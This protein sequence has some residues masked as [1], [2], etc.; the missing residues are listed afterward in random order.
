MT[1]QEVETLLEEVRPVTRS[2]ARKFYNDPD[3]SAELVQQHALLIWEG[4]RKLRR[5]KNP[6]AYV[7]ARM[8]YLCR[9]AK[10]QDARRWAAGYQEGG[11]EGLVE[12]TTHGPD[13][14]GVF[15]ENEHF[16]NLEA[17]S[18]ANPLSRGDELS[19]LRDTDVRLAV[20]NLDPQV[21]AVVLAVQVEGKSINEVSLEMMLS[22]EKVTRL[23]RDGV[24]DLQTQ[25][26]EWQR[27]KD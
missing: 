3:R 25:L 6:R 17:M 27:L 24:A 15:Q 11:Y 2:I 12:D 8:Y 9:G 21:R 23:L 5:S 10:Q 1:N 4:R 18:R 13:T 14:S 22:R 26:Q 19:T 20:Q 16:E 7:I